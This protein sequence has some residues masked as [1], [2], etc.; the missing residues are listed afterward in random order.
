[1]LPAGSYSSHDTSLILKILLRDSHGLAKSCYE[2]RTSPKG[3]SMERPARRFD[4]FF[5]SFVL[6][7]T[8]SCVI[9]AATP[10]SVNI[11]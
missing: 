2:N 10:P 11:F 8:D 4:V 1:L 3:V 7:L 9:R 5:F 6:A